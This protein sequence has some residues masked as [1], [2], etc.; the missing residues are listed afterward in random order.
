MN[1]IGNE[2]KEIIT[3]TFK[4]N[5]ISNDADDPYVITI[6]KTHRTDLR[7]IAFLSKMFD[8]S[9]GISPMNPTDKD[10]KIVVATIGDLEKGKSLDD[11][12]YMQLFSQ[13]LKEL[14][15]KAGNVTEAYSLIL[16][17]LTHVKSSI[18]KQ[19]VFDASVVEHIQNEKSKA[20]AG[21]PSFFDLVTKYNQVQDKSLIDQKELINYWY[22]SFDYYSYTDFHG[23]LI[24]DPNVIKWV[25]NHANDQMLNLDRAE[26]IEHFVNIGDKKSVNLCFKTY[27]S[28]LSDSLLKCRPYNYDSYQEDGVNFAEKLIDH[29]LDSLDKER[30]I[31]EKDNLSL[32][33]KHIL[34]MK[35]VLD[36]RYNLM[37]DAELSRLSRSKKEQEKYIIPLMKLASAYA[38]TPYSFPYNSDLIKRF[39]PEFIERS[40]RVLCCSGRIDII[41]ELLNLFLNMNNCSGKD[42]FQRTMNDF[43]READGKNLS[44]LFKLDHELFVKWLNTMPSDGYKNRVLDEL[45]NVN[46]NLAKQYSDLVKSNK[47]DGITELRDDFFFRKGYGKITYD[48][49]TYWTKPSKGGLY[50]PEIVLLDRCEKGYYPTSSDYYNY[51]YWEKHYGISAVELLKTLEARGFIKMGNARDSLALHTVSEL[52]R[53][54]D[55]KGIKSRS[56]KAD[57]IMQVRIHF[58]D[59]ELQQ[60]NIQPV[61]VLTDAG[62]RE[63]N[64]NKY[65]FTDGI[66]YKKIGDHAHVSIWEINMFFNGIVP[67]DYVETMKN[68]L[69]Q[70]EEYLLSTD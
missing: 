24:K 61:Y 48:E 70:T 62:K 28:S 17:L 49:I 23:E 45:K 1:S 11:S 16:D 38:N 27:L 10:L 46:R 25:F 29:F 66:E 22:Q 30:S 15:R 6:G 56:S 44:K 2:V 8:P 41:R 20:L 31:R 35:T 59:K 32:I 52:K 65:A 54:L 58:D 47:G 36:S 34:K 50:I 39:T 40:I 13:E 55:S 43:I 69:I 12:E 18:E 67:E 64:E 63:L 57:I 53:I 37:L 7:L 5:G 9:S 4:N 68:T 42:Q 33:K 51:D 60:F 14:L 21:A 19:I 26:I 3:Q